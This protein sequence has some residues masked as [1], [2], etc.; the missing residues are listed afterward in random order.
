MSQTADANHSDPKNETLHDC[1]GKHTL[2][3]QRRTTL[4]GVPEGF[5]RH[6]NMEE[7]GF[8][9]WG[10]PFPAELLCKEKHRVGGLGSLALATG[11]QEL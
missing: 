11:L 3:C 8:T 9:E 7:S 4:G 2:L 10:G 6:G 1:K 5:N